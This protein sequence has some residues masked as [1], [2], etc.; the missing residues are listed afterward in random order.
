MVSVSVVNLMKYHC[1]FGKISSQAVKLMMKNWHL[2]K[3]SQ[4]QLLYKENDTP[5]GFYMVIFGK[6]VMHSKDLGA[7]G[8]VSVGDFIGEELIFEKS[9]D[10]KNLAAQAEKPKHFRTETA[11]SEGDSYLLE[12]YFDD[13]P[14]L[15]DMLILMKLRNDYLLI[16]SHLKK[17]YF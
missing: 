12:C 7:I 3:L 6:I 10:V 2:I 5:L 8:M 4:D 13:W 14:K 11:Y 9:S 1:F 17:C 16:D 15:K